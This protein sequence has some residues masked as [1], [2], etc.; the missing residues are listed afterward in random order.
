MRRKISSLLLLGILACA[1]VSAQE[2]TQWVKV[3][4]SQLPESVLAEEIT[5]PQ[6]TD[7]KYRV[8]TN[9]FWENWFIYADAGGHAF[10]GDY[11]H[12]GKFK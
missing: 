7:D 1:N 12:W 3:D 9:R 5:F 10:F 2:N 4:R 6:P 8:V 11:S